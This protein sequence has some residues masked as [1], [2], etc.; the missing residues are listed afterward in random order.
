MTGAFIT[1]EGGE[2]AGKSTQIR[3]L[4][5]VLRDRGHDAVLTREPG[6]TPE[7]ERIRDVVVAP[8]HR[9]TPLAE[10]LLYYAA[11]AEHMAHL[12]R[13]ARA[14]GAVVLCD[15]FLDSTAAYQSI[16][17]GLDAQVLETLKALV[18]GPDMPDLTLILDLPPQKGLARAI[19]RARELGEAT[20]RYENMDI[21]FHERLRHAF[22]NIAAAEP[23]RCAVIDADASVEI[24]HQRVRAVV[25]AR[26]PSLGVTA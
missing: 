20:S 25:A 12:I 26:L 11:R 23:A 24:V 6:G 18:V 16:A 17:S 14:G 7:A 5:E 22:L 8:G 4:R 3:M 9:F 15:R 10:A 13:P 2:G 21:G 1:F 19:A